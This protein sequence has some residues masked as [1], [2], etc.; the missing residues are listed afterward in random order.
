MITQNK[1][2]WSELYVF[3]KLLGDGILYA[4]DAD[5]NKIENLYYPLI[6]ILRTENSKTKH[7]IRDD[8]NIKITNESGNILL[9]MPISEF[10]SKATLLLNAIKCSSGTFSVPDIENF[11]HIIMCDKVKADSSDKS[12]ITLVLH[13]YKTYRDDTFNFSIKSRLGNPSSLLNAGKT[14]NF[15][16]KISDSLSDEQIQSINNINTKSKLKDRLNAIQNASC[17]LIFYDMENSVFKANLQMVDFSFPLILSEYLLQYYFGV[18]TSVKDLT[19]KVKNI[20]PCNAEASYMIYE[21]KM[22][23]FLTDIALGMTPANIW[24]G[25]FQATGG[26]IIVRED[27]EV[28]CYHI[29]N[30]NEFQNYLFKHTRFD[31]PSTS[32][33]DFGYLY[34]ENGQNF[35]KLN[36]QIRF[37]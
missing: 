21:H 27:G 28:L 36:L 26:Y 22:K 31:T 4:A 18:A 1:G 16:Y 8:V 9:Y 24:N 29:Y 33:H 19:E 35:I 11:I 25:L 30:H 6:K 5:L 3:L 37:I 32:R 2:E 23:N 14:T 12:D 13:D 10:A 17:S 34:K 7:Y 20:N 15:I